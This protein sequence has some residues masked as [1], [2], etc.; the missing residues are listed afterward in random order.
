M[1]HTVLQPTDRQRVAETHLFLVSTFNP[2][3]LIINYL[4]LAVDTSFFHLQLSSLI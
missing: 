1:N 3:A 2:F 4:R